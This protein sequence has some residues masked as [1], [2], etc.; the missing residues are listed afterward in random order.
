MVN[1]LLH[2]FAADTWKRWSYKMCKKLQQATEEGKYNHQFLKV[3]HLCCKMDCRVQCSRYFSERVKVILTPNKMSSFFIL[4]QSLL[5][6]PNSGCRAVVVGWCFCEKY[7]TWEH[8]RYVPYQILSICKFTSDKLQ[9][10]ALSR[11][12]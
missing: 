9:Y 3:Y 4:M 8:H 7:Y 1:V 12:S 10:T 6:N 5:Y 11:Y 2:V